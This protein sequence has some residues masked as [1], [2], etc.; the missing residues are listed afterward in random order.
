MLDAERRIV[1]L[2]FLDASNGWLKTEGAKSK[3]ISTDAVDVK[4]DGFLA[5]AC[6]VDGKCANSA[7]R[8][9]RESGLRWS[10]SARCQQR[11]VGE[12]TA[13]E[14]N[15]LNVLRRQD[16]TDA[17]RHTV[18]QRDVCLDDQSFRSGTNLQTEVADEC[19]A[20]VEGQS[21]DDCRLE[22]LR[23]GGDVV[24]LGGDV[25]DMIAAFVVGLDRTVEARRV[26]VHADRCA[27]Q[28]CS[29]RIEHSSLKRGAGLR[30]DWR[31]DEQNE[32]DDEREH[33]SLNIPLAGSRSELPD[34]LAD[35]TL[36]IRCPPDDDK[37]TC[38]DG[39]VCGSHAF[40]ISRALMSL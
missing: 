15:L 14:R 2:E 24:R 4:G 25:F 12:M 31:S 10:D 8:C 36:P 16:V 19:P 28:H 34:D 21:G 20:D 37:Y 22:T 23:R 7:K 29:R 13:V 18:D 33:S 6:G 35:H 30:V 32:D 38:V 3:I 17:G 27:A 1:D 5:M 9:R 26:A 40:P 39:L 11:E